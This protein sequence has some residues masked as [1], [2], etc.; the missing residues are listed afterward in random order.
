MFRW[1]DH[2]S[3]TGRGQVFRC[4]YCHGRVRADKARVETVRGVQQYVHAWHPIQRQ[5]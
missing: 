5:R 2:S 4:G 3:R 1:V